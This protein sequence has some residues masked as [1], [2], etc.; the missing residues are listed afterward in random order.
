MIKNNKG[1]SAMI[2]YVLLISLAFVMGGIIYTWAST[3]VP[4]G[5]IGCDD[6]VSILLEN[7]ACITNNTHTNLNI[8]LKNNGRF[9]I[10]GFLIYGTNDTDQKVPTFD[11]S[12]EIVSGEY[13][14]MP[15]TKFAGDTNSLNPGLR[16]GIN[17]I[18]Y[19]ISKDDLK[20]LTLIKITPIRWQ[21]KNGKLLVLTCGDSAISEE[22]SC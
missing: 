7:A 14:L 10:G 6:G 19:S 2:G 15:G 17:P 3:Y 12:K 22:I 5:D 16:A 20:G 11:I 1:V 18:Q 4:K 21:E 13:W 9:A 8:S